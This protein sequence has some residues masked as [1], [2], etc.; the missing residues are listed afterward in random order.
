M[1]KNS[2]QEVGNDL[3]GTPHAKSQKKMTP[4]PS[5]DTKKKKRGNGR[6]NLIKRNDKTEDCVGL[7]NQGEEGIS[8]EETPM[9]L[10]FQCN[11]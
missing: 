1:W 2:R 4:P 8:A 7:G 10:S 9:D 5:F 6:H 3:T 11:S